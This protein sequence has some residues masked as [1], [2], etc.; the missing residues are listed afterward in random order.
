MYAE[1]KEPFKVFDENEES[2]VAFTRNTIIN[3][4]KFFNSFYSN[5][6]TNI[7]EVIIKENWLKYQESRR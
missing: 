2:R 7:L 6:E 4:L 1:Y 5:K 3:L